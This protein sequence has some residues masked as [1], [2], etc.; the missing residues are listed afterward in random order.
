MAHYQRYFVNIAYNGFNYRGWQRQAESPTIQ[1]IVESTLSK[2]LHRP[3]TCIGCGRTDAKVHASQYYFHFDYDEDINFDLKFRLNKILPYDIAVFRIIPVTDFPHAQHSAKLRTYNYL[4]NTQKEPFLNEL[5]SLYPYDFDLELMN[6]AVK[7][8]VN[9]NDFT[10]FCLCPVHNSR[11][12][13][14][15]TSAK[16]YRHENGKMI[17]FE[18]TANRFVQ[19]MVRLLAQRI[20]DVGTGNLSL[21]DFEGYLSNRL[22]PDKI[23][24]A[25]PQGLYLSGITYPFIEQ[26]NEGSIFGT[27]LEQGWIELK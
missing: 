5:S 2:I 23:R 14:N 27:L 8:I 20:I 10:N 22:V 25:Y 9:Y 1:E 7:M 12:D 19:G 4:I 11:T 13:C 15:I 24:R 21:S 17:R 3:I 6:S 26:T 18:I 16:L